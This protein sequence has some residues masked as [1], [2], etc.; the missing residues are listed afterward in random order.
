MNSTVKIV[1]PCPKCKNPLQIETGYVKCA[2]CNQVFKVTIRI[3]LREMKNERTNSL[4]N[5]E[6]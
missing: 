4:P 2:K 6:S 5:K 1:V 3:T